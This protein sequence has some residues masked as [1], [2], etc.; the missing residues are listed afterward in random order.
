VH[1]VTKVLKGMHLS[2]T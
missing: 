1:Y 2:Y